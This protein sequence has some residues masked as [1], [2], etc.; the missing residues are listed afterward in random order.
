MDDTGPTELDLGG[1]HFDA[2]FRGSAGATLRVSG[3][4]DGVPTELLR[5]DDFIDGPHYHFPSDA[6]PVVFDPAALGEP[7]DWL[8]VQISDHL[9][10]ILTDAGFGAVL[11]GLDLSVVTANAERIRTLMT[12]CLPEG[13]ERVSGVGLRRV[14]A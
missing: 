1:L 8:V 14:E 13:Y 4:V 11:P 12:D 9:D 7:L 6:D 5:F 2:S 3:P 10:Q